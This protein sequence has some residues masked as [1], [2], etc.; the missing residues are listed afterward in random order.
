MSKKINWEAIHTPHGS[1]ALPGAH[2][3]KYRSGR[4][5]FAKAEEQ[6][7]EQQQAQEM[8]QKAQPA[9]ETLLKSRLMSKTPLVVM[10]PLVYQTSEMV[11]TY[12]QIEDRENGGWKDDLDNA[13][14]SYFTDVQKSIRPGTQLVLKSLDPNLQEFIFE[15]QNGKEI[16]LPY[17]AQQQL[18]ISTNI[19]EDVNKFLQTYE[20]E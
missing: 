20:G 12:E 6:M 16:V 15:D 8:L 4:D 18:M 2:Q 17:V 14:G 13:R 1:R 9:M 19:Y 7:Y 11:T 10:R 5:Y 3:P